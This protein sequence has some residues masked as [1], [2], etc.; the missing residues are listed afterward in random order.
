MKVYEDL[1]SDHPRIHIST[2]VIKIKYKKSFLI[3]IFTRLNIYLVSLPIF[4]CVYNIYVH[5]DIFL[6]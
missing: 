6:T 2:S 4:M 3:F 5:I 1:V